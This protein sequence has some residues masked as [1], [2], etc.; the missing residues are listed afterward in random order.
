MM[1]TFTEAIILATLDGAG[2]GFTFIPLLLFMSDL[3]PA[4]IYNGAIGL[5][6]TFQDIGGIL[7]PIIFI[8]L[9]TL[10]DVYP[11]FWGAFL[12]YIKIKD[13]KT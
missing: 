11:P 7:G 1:R 8:I 9:Y 12:L 5:Y 3:V 2:E 13:S 10:A 4:S 6:R